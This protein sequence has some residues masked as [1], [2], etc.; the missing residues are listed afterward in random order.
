M[1][2][3]SAVI[4]TLVMI[5]SLASCSGSVPNTVNSASD[6]DG[7]TIGVLSS[8]AAGIVL[9]KSAKAFESV[10]QLAAALSSGA[11]D[12]VVIDSALSSRVTRAGKGIKKLD[13]HYMDGKWR[14]AI[15]KENAD[16]TEAVN[17]AIVELGESGVLTGI[18]DYYINLTGDGYT[19]AEQETTDTLVLAADSS[20]YPYAYKDAFDEWR[21]L[22]ID[23]MRAICDRLGVGLEIHDVKRDVL[24][25]EVWYG[26]AHFSVGVLPS[27]EEALEKIDFSH[28]YIMSPQEILVRR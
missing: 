27:T 7:K 15:A 17:D 1:K 25:D 18:F 11:V 22:D 10:E 14:I 26:R 21:G 23:C 16:L 5:L 20:L 8:S 2:R 3:I 4:L 19:P 28:A 13:E 24:I 12:C 9:G 6:V